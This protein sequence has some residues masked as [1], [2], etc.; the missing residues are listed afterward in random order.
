MGS[1]RQAE[2]QSC[3]R[4][5][6]AALPGTWREN[7]PNLV[8]A[9]DSAPAALYPT[10]LARL[11]PVAA[12][13][14]EAYPEPRGTAAEGYM[15]IRRF[16]PELASGPAQYGYVSLYKTWLCSRAGEVSLA[17]ETGNWAYVFVNSLHYLLDEVLDKPLIVDGRPT[18]VWMLARRIGTLRGST[19]YEPW[20]GLDHGRALVFAREGRFPWTPVSQ[21][22]YLDALAS[23]FR[24]QA[25]ETS[26]AVDNLI[27]N[28]EQAIAEARQNVPADIRDAVVAEMERA[29][30]DARAQQPSSAAKLAVGV[31]EE[32]KLIADYQASHSEAELAQPAVLPAGMTFGFNGAFGTESDGG[33]ML[34]RTDESYFRSDLSA[35]AAQLVTLLWKWENGNLASDA[36]RDA[37]ERLFPIDRLRA[38]V[39]R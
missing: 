18:R 19:L 31:A 23:W 20:M 35:D 24:Q 12:M 21:K 39:D 37:L 6:V 33:H 1:T 8:L 14:R 13:L 11:A 29:L 7:P 2:A 22:Q 3:T 34:V 10:I 36:W 28:M 25:V 17:G 15:S 4:E 5:S 38:M 26:D 27:R 30:A 16:G 32:L 9:S